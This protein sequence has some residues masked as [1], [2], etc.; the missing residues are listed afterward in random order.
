[1]LNADFL[2]GQRKLQPQE[3]KKNATPNKLH[4]S[5]LKPTPKILTFKIDRD[6]I[7]LRNFAVQDQQIY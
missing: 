1:M 3:D 5:Q 6:P 2:F 4:F 7:I